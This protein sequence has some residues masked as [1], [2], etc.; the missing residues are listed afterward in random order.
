MAMD[1]VAH[2]DVECRGQHA[3]VKRALRIEEEVVGFEGDFAGIAGIGDLQPKE[4]GEEE[5]AEGFL[6]ASGGA[7]EGCMG[8]GKVNPAIHA[9]PPASRVGPHPG[10]GRAWGLEGARA[11]TRRRSAR[12][13]PGCA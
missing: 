11:A 9:R 2:G 7:L 10:A 8:S 1:Q 6:C 13:R 5:V 3:P 4:A 12:E